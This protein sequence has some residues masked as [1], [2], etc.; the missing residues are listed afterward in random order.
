M[1]KS[2]KNIVS[3]SVELYKSAETGL[4]F[5]VK[6]DGETIWLTQKQMSQLF[7]KGIPTINEHIKNVYKE[8]ELEES[9]TIR[10]FRI[11]QKEGKR[12]VE[13]DVDFYNLDVI[14]SVGYRVKSNQGTK[15]R[16]WATNV[17]RDH[18]LRKRPQ[19]E[20]KDQDLVKVVKLIGSVSENYMLSKDE[21]EGLIRVITDYTYALDVLDQYD[22][23]KLKITKGQTKEEYLITYEDSLKVI[24]ELKK[25]FGGSRLFGKEKDKSFQGSLK[26]IYQ[27][28]GRNQLYPTLEEK[29]AALLYF[30]IKNH[31]FIDGNKRIAAA[32]FLMY[33]A[34]NN[35]LYRSDG[36][37]RIADNA[38]V[39][40]CLL[41]AESHPKEKDMIMKVIVN[42]INQ[43]N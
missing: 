17:L 31:S 4:E 15:F 43:K 42:L 19:L 30:T 16:I 20:Y 14:I 13:R 25:T 33:L 8:G 40:L 37:K 27:T 41:I 6:V 21:T 3:E 39:A 12:D 32:V 5:Q 2:T 28:Y 35:F 10:K 22:T 29:A 23:Q 9:P 26:N 1:P 36:N 7:Q 34:R 11:V 24:G 38:L 18:L